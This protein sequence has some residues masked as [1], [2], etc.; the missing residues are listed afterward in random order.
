MPNESVPTSE[1][2]AQ[3]KKLD[4]DLKPKGDPFRVQFNPQSLSVNYNSTLSGTKDDD[5]SEKQQ[6]GGWSTSMDVEL[7]F[8]VTRPTGNGDE[9][10]AT[11]VRELTKRVQKFM[12]GG[13]KDGQSKG[14]EN[15]QK[16]PQP[17]VRFVWGSFQYDGVITRMN[18][19]LEFFD[20]EG[21]PLRA[22]VSIS[23]SGQKPQQK[24]V[25]GPD[26]SSVGGNLRAGES[27]AGS[28]PEEPPPGAET[29]NGTPLQQLAGEVGA[30][31]NWKDIAAQNG[32][33]NPRSI[34]NPGAV[35][36]SAGASASASA[37][38]SASGSVSG[39]ISG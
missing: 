27:G 11:D 28:G 20:P 34:H 9:S 16:G 6:T 24:E 31:G 23:L 15:G 3:L 12:Q 35:D 10:D 39:S 29:T 37:S 4:N 19:N 8:D 21:R 17:N 30:Q 33:D 14:G 36:L 25:E 18:E 38:G 5:E 2:R 26:V 32:I 1:N 22:I 13:G 7:F